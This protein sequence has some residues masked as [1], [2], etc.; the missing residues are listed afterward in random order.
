MIKRYQKAMNIIYICVCALYAFLIVFSFLSNNSQIKKIKLPVSIWYVTSG[1]MQP[2]YDVND[3][4]I[5]ISSKN[6]KKGDIITFKA[7]KLK[8]E[9]VTHR[10]D[11][12]KSDG[13]MITKGDNNLTTDQMDSEPPISKNAVIGKVLTIGKKAVVLKK[14]GLITGY[15]KNIKNIFKIICILIAVYTLHFI[16]EKFILKSNSKS[17]R[18]LILKDIAP[19]F[20]YLFWIFFVLLVLNMLFISTF[21]NSYNSEKL[22]FVV[23]STDGLKNPMPGEEYT[24]KQVIENKTIIPLVTIFKTEEKDT[25]IRPEIVNLAAKSQAEYTISLKAPDKTGY[26]SYDI[27]KLVYPDILPYE[28]FTRLY[29]RGDM[30]PLIIIFTPGI[31]LLIFVYAAWM[32]KWR[33]RNAVI[34]DWIIPIRGSINKLISM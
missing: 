5:L 31:L 11:S 15:I 29:S 17:K 21:I 12:I 25:I 30:L 14:L 13:S 8:S 20:D 26:Y 23:V 22:S 24:K 6:Y 7:E 18:K 4:F 10:I 3:G 33:N 32:I 19:Y 2:L 16:F 9:Y 27:K 1:S 34:M 28:W